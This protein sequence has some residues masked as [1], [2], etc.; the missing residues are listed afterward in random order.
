[1]MSPRTMMV[2]KMMAQ[3]R[4]LQVFHWPFGQPRVLLFRQP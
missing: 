1:M 4:M 2:R 3:M